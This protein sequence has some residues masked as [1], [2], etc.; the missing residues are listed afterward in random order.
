M[1]NYNFFSNRDAVGAILMYDVTNRITFDKLDMWLNELEING[2]KPNMAK[3]LVGNKIDRPDRQ[4]AREEGLN[5]A[6]KHRML[7]VETSA[8]TSENVMNVFEEIVRKIVET[9][10]L[11]DRNSYRPNVNLNE[12]N[13]AAGTFCSC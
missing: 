4:V 11:W 7:F 2:N 8:K 9:D 1:K 5:F 10:N 6:R 12:G 3:M 13:G